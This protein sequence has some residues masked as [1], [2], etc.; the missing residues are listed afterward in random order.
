[1]EGLLSM[2]PTPSSLIVKLYYIIFTHAQKLLQSLLLT[3]GK[4]ER[5]VDYQLFVMP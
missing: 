2:G 1:M 5:N 4:V 3:S